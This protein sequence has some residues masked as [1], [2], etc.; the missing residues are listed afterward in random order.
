MVVREGERVS[1]DQILKLRAIRESGRDNRSLQTAAGLIICILLLFYVGFYFGQKNISKF[2]PDSRDLLFLTAVFVALFVLVKLSI[3]FSAGMSNTFAYL[4]SSVY[5][6]A[7]PFALGAMLVRIVLNSETAFL[8]AVSF[9]FLVGVLFGNNLLMALYVLVGSLV[10]AHGVRQCQARTTLYRAGLWIGLA[11]MALLLGIHFL[12]GRVFELA[13]LW[14]SGLVSLVAL[15]VLFLS[16]VRFRWS[17]LSSNI[18]PI[19]SCLNW[20]T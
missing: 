5:Y 6:Y 1:A 8:F 20:P 16:M 11:N 2:K 13:L 3:I 12:S 4:D 9:A 15:S 18:R 17:S 7:V 19:S 10:G 14:N